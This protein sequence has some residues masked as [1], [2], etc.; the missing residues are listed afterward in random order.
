MWFTKGIKIWTSRFR[1]NLS[2]DLTGWLK[3]QLESVLLDSSFHSMQPQPFSFISFS[4]YFKLWRNLR[5]KDRILLPNWFTIK[6]V[7][8][9]RLICWRIRLRFKGMIFRLSRLRLGLLL[10]LSCLGWRLLSQKC[11]RL[12][13]RIERWFLICSMDLRWKMFS[14]LKRFLLRIGMRLINTRS[15]KVKIIIDNL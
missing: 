3:C 13:S 1:T 14:F 15:K 4:I 11:L 2:L 5:R 6:R 9:F 10:W 7:N 12:Y 8:R